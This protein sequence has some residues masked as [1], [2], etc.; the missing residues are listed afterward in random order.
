M[1]HFDHTFKASLHTTSGHFFTDTFGA[2]AFVKRQVQVVCKG[3]SLE[4][5]EEVGITAK[6]VS[7][8]DYENIA[9]LS[10]DHAASEVKI[11]L[12]RDDDEAASQTFVILTMSN[13]IELEGELKLRFISYSHTN[14]SL[15][16]PSTMYMG[17]FA[18][19]TKPKPF[20]RKRP[21]L[22]KLPSG[23]L[24]SLHDMRNLAI[25][26]HQGSYAPCPAGESRRIELALQHMYEGCNTFPITTVRGNNSVANQWRLESVIVINDE[27]IVFKPNGSM[28]GGQTI[29][30][31][32]DQIADWTAIDH[33]NQRLNESGIEI[34]SVGSGDT[35]FFGV[36]Y[37]R[38]VKHTLEYFW[39]HFQ[40]NNGKPVML[41]STHGRPL[42]QVTTLSGEMEPPEAPQ[43]QVEVV[44]QDGVQVR[45]GARL[46]PRRQSMMDQVMGNK[47][48]SVVPPENKKVK[49]HWHQ[50]VMH[51]GWLLKKGG[52]GV[53]ANKAWIKRYFVLYKTSQ[54]HFLVYYSDFTECPLYTTEKNHRNVVDL[55]KATFI[56]PGS[57]MS[58]N[59]A[60]DIP[61][62]SFDI[63]TT[64]REWT[65]CAESQENVA[66]WLKLLTRAVDEDV[67]ILPDEDLLFQVKPKQSPNSLLNPNDYSTRLLV[68]ATGVSVCVPDPNSKDSSVQKEVYFWVYTDFYKWSLV[69]QSGKLALLVNVFADPSFSRRDEY[70]FRHKEA[71]RLATAIEFYIEKFMTVMHIRLET[72]EQSPDD[73][74]GNGGNGDG[75]DRGMHIASAEEWDEDAQEGDPSTSEKVTS[76]M[77]ELDLLGLDSPGPAKRGGGGA[78][79]FGGDP[80]AEEST[81]T[82]PP[83]PPSQ[84]P[85]S[86]PSSSSS[87]SSST[88]S[89]PFGSSNPFGDDP[90][91]FTPPPVAQG[92]K[93]AP[94]LTAQQ[95]AQ[96]SAWYVAAMQKKGGPLYDDGTLQISTKIE[97]RGSQARLTFAMRNHSAG[98]MTNFELSV[99]DT[100]GLIRFQLNPVVS[101]VNAMQTLEHIMMLECMKPAAP[102]PVLKI[103][104]MDSLLGQRETSVDLLISVT[105]FIEPLILSGA[106]FSARWD[107]LQ[108]NGQHAQQ[109]FNPSQAVVPARIAE[110]LTSLL[111]FGRVTGMPDESEF[112]IYGAGS[113]RTGSLTPTGEKISV[114]CLVKIEMNVQANALRL[115]IR[116]LHPAATA[117]LQSTGKALLG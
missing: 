9:E 24:P 81:T 99:D 56:R 91:G 94:P 78:D 84:Y 89:D 8:V 111:Q 90:F 30:F 22:S 19:A 47:E 50:V 3:S 82:R 36:R 54:G 92:P 71:T 98:T 53:G 28:Q 110:A 59:A 77:Q 35:V 67:A 16:I 23:K 70:T 103:K 29:T 95:K 43:G 79:P 1:H 15:R 74:D 26:L 63:V 42:V 4:I 108:G 41:G 7:E 116:T 69:S 102:G 11:V 55:A 60:A 27:S 20:Q 109:V 113:L 72:M 117:A 31:H 6:K 112:V 97:V 101:T 76:Q 49:R 83:A 100:A 37:I 105:T 13:S 21:N 40:V 39:N 65:L 33:Q 38:D 64:E 87:S 73:A 48:P 115:T 18:G 2:C 44:D 12:N 17:M 5:S 86:A 10:W 93:V 88:S 34:R 52:I 68:S 85:Y 104:Y 57:N 25:Q 58:D 75:A 61:P 80:F 14:R 62:H 45:P 106:D 114:G 32:F 51:Q 96:H 66:K 46:A 107:Q